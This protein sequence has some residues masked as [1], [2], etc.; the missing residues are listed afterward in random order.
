MAW[1]P[2][3]GV[4]F[5]ARWALASDPLISYPICSMYGIFTYISHKYMPNVGKYSIHGA[6]GYGISGVVIPIHVGLIHGGNWGYDLT[7]KGYFISCI[8]GLWVHLV[9]KT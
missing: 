6:S 1:S 5:L 4:H 9:G 8:I 3:L 2:S 7:S